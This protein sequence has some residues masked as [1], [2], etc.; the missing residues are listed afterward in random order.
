MKNFKNLT[1]TVITSIIVTVL[2]FMFLNINFKNV[3]PLTQEVKSKP[4]S[5]LLVTH[6]WVEPKIDVRTKE[7]FI[8][9]MN[10]CI[11]YLYHD[12][13]KADW[14]KCPTICLASELGILTCHT[15]FLWA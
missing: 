14:Q 1:V 2:M 6:E 13:P 10:A 11:N 3:Q 12:T 5:L 15:S 4:A 8:L 7:S 9:S